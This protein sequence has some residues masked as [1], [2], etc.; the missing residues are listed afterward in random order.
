MSGVTL[1][2]VAQPGD[3]R[4]RP[5]IEGLRALAVS[6][7]V[8]FH[9]WPSA[10]PGG[11]VG[12]DVFFVV[13]GFLITGLLL[14]EL[15]SGGINLGRFYVRRALRLLPA[16]LVVI[17][18]TSLASVILL[19]P[20]RW[21][22]V[23][24]EA[25]AS[26]AY[27]ENW[28]LAW[29]A[30]DYLAAEEA[31]SPFQHFWSLSIE[32]QF[33]L[34]WPIAILGC[35]AIARRWRLPPKRVLLFFTTAAFATSLLLS[36][37][38]ALGRDGAAYFHT[39]NRV[40][41][42]GAGALLALFPA[43]HALDA[44]LRAAFGFIGVLL[45]LYA[46]FTYG[47]ATAYP[48]FAAAAP[49]AGAVC[50]IVSG[51]SSAWWNVSTLL[52]TTPARWLGGLS[53][54]LY[55]VHWPLVTFHHSV[56]GSEI[57]VPTGLALIAATV[58]LSVLL[59]RFVE[60]RFRGAPVD[61]AVPAALRLGGLATV[62]ALG[63]CAWVFTDLSA[64]RNAISAHPESYPGGAV[65]AGVS[66]PR[67]ER[68]R[69]AP[70]MFDLSGDRAD[71]YRNGCHLGFDSTEPVACEYGNPGGQTRVV[72][73]GDS[74]AANW[75]PALAAVA[76]RR[77]WR[78]TSYTKSSC[79]LSLRM[80]KRQ[81]R[82]YAACLEWSRNVQAELV[83]ERPDLL[84]LAG[85]RAASVWP[86]GASPEP[87]EDVLAATWLQLGEVSGT[88]VAIA[89]TPL[90]RVDP[91]ACLFRDPDC[92]RPVT[93]QPDPFVVAARSLPQ[94]GLLDMNDVVCPANECPAVIG[95]VIVW[96]DRH[97]LTAT[98]SRSLA[99]ILDSRLDA[100]LRGV[101]SADSSSFGVVG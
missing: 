99:P 33:Y 93:P 24:A 86:S 62:T 7:V 44:R 91:D 68:A 2:G 45:I 37:D 46:G 81:G 20:S 97:H 12:V 40:W 100:L 42:L 80:L 92:R 49:V 96:R 32:E 69:F 23:A 9:V 13:S 66:A 73:V 26:A 52:S 51:Q 88:I 4:F 14:R 47:P 3:R 55:L 56:V 5:E 25:V 50:I 18:V 90:W 29:R 98:Y 11:F 95:N 59:K 43:V 21:I 34:V 58:L 41:Q 39:Q 48:G 27:V 61:L 10:L 89:D 83:R 101:A 87:L 71:V 77:G 16:A 57:G 76:E 17:G 1:D 78:L 72:L 36:I 19:P 74:H 53:Y 75:I 82:P 84:I 94:V 30:V 85:M 54:S 67:V 6:L 28:F 65:L 8:V 35:V 60:D 63:V 70:T 15:P 22:V 31:A 79:P 38:A 64:R